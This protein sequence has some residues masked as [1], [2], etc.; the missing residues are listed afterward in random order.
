MNRLKF[1]KET[2][3][4]LGIVLPIAGLL[5]VFAID[6]WRQVR[7]GGVIQDRVEAMKADG[8]VTNQLDAMAQFDATLQRDETGKYGSFYLA[9]IRHATWWDRDVREIDDVVPPGEPW[10]AAPY[11][12]QSVEQ[13][14]VLLEM[15]PDFNETVSRVWT[16]SLFVNDS[17]SW[18]HGFSSFSLYENAYRA[19]QKAFHDGKFDDALAGYR[20]NGDSGL[21]RKSLASKGWNDEQLAA[22]REIE[23][24]PIDADQRWTD[25][26]DLALSRTCIRL[27]LESPAP[28]RDRWER[29]P[30][31]F[32]SPLGVT[33]SHAS[34]AIA[35]LDAAA[36]LRPA[37]TLSHVIRAAEL[38]GEMRFGEQESSYSVIAF[39]FA[40]AEDAIPGRV[41]YLENEAA[42]LTQ[43]ILDQK[44][45]IA[46]IA[47]RQYEIQEGRLPEKID[48]LKA[49]GLN[50]S[51]F[52]LSRD[53]GLRLQK[54][55]DVVSL[56][57]LDVSQ[58]MSLR[59]MNR[60]E[61]LRSPDSLSRG[62]K[63]LRMK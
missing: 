36:R 37:G 33:P 6:V 20:R 22:L 14:K 2:F 9:S 32:L 34:S 51:D 61:S 60:L 56:S 27:G 29:D 11:V 15:I 25:Q 42:S 13:E 10:D 50:E 4:W 62:W 44:W 39:P 17:S 31:R 63:E 41:L 49:V 53:D 48:D 18:R 5:V 43:S 52:R 16:P 58:Y 55:G 3:Y 19:F 7:I 59:K 1:G 28:P 40:M 23:S 30:I 47:V 21:L 12:D 35:Y 54:Q 46:A 45:T 38:D 24:E 8:L 26:I 57:C